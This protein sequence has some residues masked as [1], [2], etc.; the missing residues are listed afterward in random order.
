LT[1]TR[2]IHRILI[3]ES[4][5]GVIYVGAQGSAWGASEDRGVFK[6]T[7]HGQSW[8]KILY[9]NDQTG[10]ADLVMDPSNPNKIMAAMWEYGRT[11]AFF[12]SG[13]PG[14]GL[15]I[16]HDGGQ[17]WDR[18]EAEDGFP[19][20]DL[21]RIG[22]AIAPSQPSTVYAIVEAKENALYKSEVEAKENALYKSEDGGAKWHKVGAH[23][24]MGNRPF[25][26]SEIYVDP[27]NENRLYSLWTYLSK[28]ED[29]GRTF[30]IIADYGNSVHPDHHALWISPTDSDYIINGNDGGMNFTYD[31]G[32][33]WRFVT[34]LPVGQFYHVNV[35]DDFPYNVYGGMQDNGSWVGPAFTLKAGGITNHDWQEV[36]FGDGFDIAPKPGDNRYV[37][38]MSQGGN[39]GLVDKETGQTQFVK[40]NHQDSTP[41]R[42]NWNAAMALEPGR[43]C[44]IYYGS[45]FVHYSNDCGQSW[46][47]IS[48][49][50]T[51]N[52]TTKQK[53]HISG[54]LTIDATNAENNT[55]LIAI[56][57]SAVNSEVIWAGSDDGRLHITRNGGESWTDVY[58]RLPG[59]PSAGWI[60]QIQVGHSDAGEAWVVVNNYRQNDWE[61]YLYHTQDYGTTWQRKVRKGDVKS[62]VTSV[63]QDPEQENLVYLGTDAGLYIS[64]D[65]GD[66][67][68]HFNEGLPSVQIRDIAHQKTF[69]D[70][71]LGTFGRAFWVIDDL[72]VF[73]SMAQED[74]M[75][76]S[77][78]IVSTSPAYLGQFRSYQGIR[79]YGQGEFIADNKTTNPVMSIWVKPEDKSE[80]KEKK[81][82][83]SDKAD[84]KDKKA[85]MNMIK[86][87]VLNS[88]ADTI[89]R[90]SRK[91]DKEDGLHRIAWNLQQDGVLFPSRRERQP[92]SDPPGGVQVLPG[93]YKVIAQYGSQAD[94]TT[95]TV[96]RDPRL[97]MTAQQEQQAQQA[98]KEY[99]EVVAIATEQ[100]HRITEAKKTL[101]VL[102]AMI[103]TIQDTTQNEWKKLS[104]EHH[105]SIND[106][107]LLFM[108]AQGL[109]GIQ[110]NPN[111]LNAYLGTARRYI[112][113]SIGKPGANAQVAMDK[114]KDKTMEVT[115]KIDQYMSSGWMDL[116]EKVNL[117]DFD[118]FKE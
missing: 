88:D 28:S 47:V 14:S 95:I 97:E 90:F 25:Y 93:T 92:D 8:E 84:E 56:A 112:G 4:K 13:G 51:T 21:G 78:K 80:M 52:D 35:D 40:P 72:G 32:E 61:P 10:I 118:I 38:A 114:A 87:T 82:A 20:G 70:L 96:S 76:D 116:K 5:D 91:I 48:P 79:F 33:N 60:P 42:F 55:C 57:P 53:Q 43:E 2:V 22:V 26:Y 24:N 23:E 73:R 102:D 59:A 64:I 11:P 16:T 45:Q 100:F 69:D 9:I 7:D 58:S 74:Y 15:H 36:Y 50:L 12:N 89:R 104:K 65:G 41:L 3:D 17:T 66:Q 101:K 62:F 86:F 98:M 1:D 107:E 106:L 85:N 39:V 46:S 83:K 109:K 37:Y 115:S 94:S 71:V 75:S 103:S 117:F 105:K 18:V 44:G 31:Q 27:Q 108:D 6:T 63:L 29:G 49:D 34:N 30:E 68:H 19:S 99:E 81:D 111:N 113:S 54:G 77:L 110:R 67:W